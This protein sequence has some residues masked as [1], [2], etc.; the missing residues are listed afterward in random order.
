[1]GSQ[2]IPGCRM[3][4]QKAMGKRVKLV[5]EKNGKKLIMIL[6]G[7]GELELMLFIIQT[8]LFKYSSV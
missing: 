1:M 4:S 5:C 7:F 3:S 2:W 6:T 8:H